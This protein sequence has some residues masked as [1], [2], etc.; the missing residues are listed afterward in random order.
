MPYVYILQ[1][2]R[3]KYYVG[4]TV[5]LG[6]RL[7]QHELG[8]TQTTRNMECPELVFSQEFKTLEQARK[9]ELKIKNWKRRDYIEK[10]V[11]DGYIRMI[12]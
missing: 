12:V 6:T 11:K 5:D 8:H 2:K 7:K 9:I 10:I 1:D 4:S 3:E